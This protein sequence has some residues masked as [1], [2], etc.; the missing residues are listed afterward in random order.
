[1]IGFFCSCVS[2]THSLILSYSLINYAL[3]FCYSFSDPLFDIPEAPVFYP[4]PEEFANPTQYIKSIAPLVEPFG[5]CRIVPPKK[6][7]GGV[8]DLSSFYKNIEPTRFKFQT[9][10]QSVHRMQNR[11][12]PNV[13][14]L[15]KLQKFYAA[16]GKQSFLRNFPQFE[17]RDVDLYKLYLEVKRLGGFQRVCFSSLL[18]TLITSHH[19]QSYKITHTLFLDEDGY[20]SLSL[21]VII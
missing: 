13:I 12:G 4:T 17:G 21:Y 2:L 10:A 8:W 16:N 5:I 6:Q 15:S 3:G 18:I 19:T 11:K 7:D 9:K 20:R 14:F 1:L